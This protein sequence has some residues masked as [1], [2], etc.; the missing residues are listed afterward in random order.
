LLNT[1]YPVID[2]LSAISEHHNGSRIGYK[3]LKT[4]FE[5]RLRPDLLYMAHRSI[6]KTAATLTVQ[7]TVK[8]YSV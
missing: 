2:A 4:P 6:E 5:R 1:T 8:G 7:L 3:P